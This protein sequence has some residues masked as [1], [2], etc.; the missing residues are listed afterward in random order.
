[1]VFLTNKS[2][3]VKTGMRY[4]TGAMVEVPCDT[5]EF[6]ILVNLLVA[7]QNVTYAQ[8]YILYLISAESYWLRLR[9]NAYAYVRVFAVACWQIFRGLVFRYCQIVV[10]RTYLSVFVIVTVSAVILR[11]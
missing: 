1:V 3:Y 4:M 2:S 5:Q 11:K 9:L 8:L 6:C 7:Y 10:M